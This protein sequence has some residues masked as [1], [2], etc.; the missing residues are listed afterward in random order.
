VGNGDS[1]VIGGSL[2]DT[3]VSG[4]GNDLI[5]GDHCHVAFN[6]SWYCGQGCV[7]N[8]TNTRVQASMQLEFVVTIF[9]NVTGGMWAS[10]AV[11]RHIAA[12]SM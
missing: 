1:V 10:L 5:C 4:S 3:I 9:P 8:A 2:A 6:A 11:L 7:P 12:R